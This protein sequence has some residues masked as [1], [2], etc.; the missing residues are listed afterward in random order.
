LLD[1]DPIVVTDDLILVAGA[2]RLEAAKRLGLAMI[3]VR[4]V[5]DLTEQERHIIE[6]E[7]NLKRKNLTPV[8]LSQSTVVR[9]KAVGEH[10]R[11]QAETQAAQGA[12]PMYGADVITT[13]GASPEPE[14][15]QSPVD[16]VPTSGRVYQ[17]KPDSQKNVAAEIGMAQ[18]K[19]SDAQ[20]HVEAVQRYPELGVPDV[21]R[22]EA[23][24]LARAWD[25]MRPSNRARAR[26]VWSAEREAR[27]DQAKGKT[28]T[29]KTP[30]P[31]AKKPRGKGDPPATVPAEV[32]LIRTWYTFTAGLLQLINDFEHSGGTAP[33]L[34]YWTPEERARAHGQ[35]D[36]RLAQVERIRRELAEGT[37]KGVQA[38]AL[39][40]IHGQDD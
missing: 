3:E 31:K 33:L 1:L 15:K 29:G 23:L 13:T 24:R 20:R 27:K 12:A 25:A 8:E 21:S 19:M 37:T 26:K 28:R 18:S 16:R 9:A 17:K 6:V 36:E 32:R 22:R 39:R 40:V 2:R 30:T 35:L 11:E 14:G 10:L 38:G 4:R 5:G 34:E 7:E